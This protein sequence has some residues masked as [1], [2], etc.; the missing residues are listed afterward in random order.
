MVDRRGDRPDGPPPLQPETTET[1]D[2]DWDD[3]QELA[4][5]YQLLAE[6]NQIINQP[7]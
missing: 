2:E 5:R 6:I 4:D 1:T 3:D 7:L